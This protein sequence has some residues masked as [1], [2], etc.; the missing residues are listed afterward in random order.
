MHP[1][2]TIEAALRC[3]ARGAN[4]T[5]IG[6]ELGIPRATVRDWLAGK[7]PHKRHSYCRASPCTADHHFSELPRAY[8]YLLGLYLGDGCLA[9]HPRGVH[10]LRVSLDARY[11][12]I[13]N[14][15]VAAIREVSPANRVGHVYHGT[16]IEVNCYSK[17]W[18]CLFPQHGPGKKHERAIVLADWQQALVDRWPEQLVRG[19]IH[20]DGCRF[21][22]TGRNWSWPRY[23]FSNRS[24]DIRS[25]FCDACDKLGVHWTA[26]GKYTI[27][28]SR[29]ADV[30]TLDR[31]IGPKR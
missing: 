10:R 31:F 1:Q 29:K 3:A 13:I 25:I 23:G 7:V 24:A 20:S 26:S 14:S 16:W 9:A 27:Y 4:A 21:Q 2:S 22:N 19:L 8:V 28:V 15:C 30:A 17:S 18:M 6:R 5:E 11:P 12:E